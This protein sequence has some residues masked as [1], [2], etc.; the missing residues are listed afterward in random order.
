MTTAKEEENTK[1]IELNYWRKRIFI[2]LW[3]TYGTFYLTRVNMSIALPLIMEEFG[4]SRTAMGAVLTALFAF[5]AFG[6][7]VNGQLGDKFGSRKFITIGLVATATL[8]IAFGFANGLSV[9]ILIWGLNGYFQSMGWAPTVKT[10][11]NWFPRKIRGKFGGAL[12]TSYQIGNAYSWVLAGFV[13]G[14]LGWRWCFWIPAIIV[15][16]SAIHWYLRGRNAPEEV[17]LPTIEEECKGTDDARG[18]REDCHLGFRYTLNSVLRTRSIWL[19]AFGLF[20]LNIVR[21][22]F[23][24]WAPTYMFQ[25][26]HA[27]ISTAAYKALAIPL[28]GSVGA[29]FSGWISDKL[30]QSRRAPIAAVM[31]LLLGLFAWLYPRIPVSQWELSLVV[32]IMVGFLTYGP[33]VLMV[34]TMPMDFA[35]RKAAASATGF[36]DGMGYIGA[37]ITGILSGWLIDNLGWYSAFYFWVSAAIMAAI[38]MAILWNYKAAEGKYQ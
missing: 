26:Q 24:D 28:A 33:H 4:Y 16:V 20:G 36:I 17:G 13:A 31:L 12:G 1:S 34:T 6:Q 10:L 25:I 30:F 11:A 38:L 2:S 27:P 32:L 35:T 3:V 19:V 7:F 22:G 23:I 15:V 8:N 14:A 9:M 18:V 5:Y 37:A 21:Y 29:L